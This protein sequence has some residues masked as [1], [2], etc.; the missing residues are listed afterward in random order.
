MRTYKRKTERGKT[1]LDVF[2]RAANEVL[3]NG[4]SLRTVAADFDINFMTLQRFCKRQQQ[5]ENEGNFI[6]IQ[7]D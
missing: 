5:R 3:V 7:F 4:K 1:G 2:E 6:M